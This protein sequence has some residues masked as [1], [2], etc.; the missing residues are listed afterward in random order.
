MLWGLTIMGCENDKATSLI[1]TDKG[2]LFVPRDWKFKIDPL[3]KA[4]AEG[5]WDPAPNQKLKGL[6]EQEFPLMIDEGQDLPLEAVKVFRQGYAFPSRG[7]R[8]KD[9]NDWG[10]N[11][12]KEKNNM[13]CEETKETGFEKLKKAFGNKVHKQKYAINQEVYILFVR[14]GLKTLV[15]GRVYSLE[16]RSDWFTKEVTER[17]YISLET[18]DGMHLGD[19]EI[20][21]SIADYKKR[22]L[23][24]ADEKIK[25]EK[26]E[27]KK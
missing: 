9:T 18:G 19:S 10:V 26:E 22:M 4:L 7:F 25:L 21:S 27:S 17:Y 2:V 8:L 14:E 13:C 3:H 24:I 12:M 1:P 6:H 20:F 23:A 16:S 5:N 15:K 11:N